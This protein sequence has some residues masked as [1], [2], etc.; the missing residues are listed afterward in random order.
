[1]ERKPRPDVQETPEYTTEEERARGEDVKNSTKLDVLQRA[2][3]K[4]QVVF[5]EDVL[6]VLQIKLDDFKRKLS[7]QQ[8]SSPSFYSMRM[9]RFHRGYGHWTGTLISGRSKS[10][11]AEDSKVTMTIY[12]FIQ[13][14]VGVK[15]I[16]VHDPAVPKIVSGF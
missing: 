9:R 15:W 1:M 6:T 3:D 4:I 2:E 14:V 5:D 13:L 11:Y 7:S 12:P 10:W 16:S 8:M